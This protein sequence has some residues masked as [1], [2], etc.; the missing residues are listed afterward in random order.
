MSTCQEILQKCWLLN[1]DV[2]WRHYLKE[3]L[4]LYIFIT[5][6]HRIHNCRT[7]IGQL[8]LQDDYK[9]LIQR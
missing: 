3:M 9:S 2:L 6:R 4:R 1:V 5:S 7:F 8:L